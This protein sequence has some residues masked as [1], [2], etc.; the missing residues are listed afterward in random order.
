MNHYLEHYLANEITPVKQDISDLNK[1]FAR[2]TAL[3][4]TLG[5]P[6]LFFKNKK[7]L[8]VGAGGGYNP[9]VTQSFDLNS[10][11]I[12]EPNKHARD[13]IDMIFSQY[14]VEMKNIKV[15]GCMLEN[16]ENDTKYD[17]VICEGMIPGLHNK[18]EVLGIL[19]DLLKPNGIMLLTC[20]DEVS[21]LFE[22]LRHY[23]ACLLYTSDAAD[24]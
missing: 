21:F 3:Y 19:D 24:E 9:L 6:P 12:V 18:K 5:V 20:I 17:V 13:D 10:Y 15:H 16:Y 7:I 11:D 2:R 1:H 14:K 23:I 8:E 4:N 22:I